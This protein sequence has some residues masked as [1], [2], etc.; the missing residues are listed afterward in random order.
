MEQQLSEFKAVIY[1][2]PGC[3]TSNTIDQLNQTKTILSKHWAPSSI[4]VVNCAHDY[5]LQKWLREESGGKRIFPQIYIGDVRIGS[6]TDLLSAQESGLLALMCNQ[7]MSSSLRL[8]LAPELQDSDRESDEEELDYDDE[9]DGEVDPDFVK[10]HVVTTWF[11]AGQWILGV[12]KGVLHFL[13]SPAEQ[14]QT[15]PEESTE[16]LPEVL[17]ID[18][19]EAIVTEPTTIIVEE[20]ILTENF[21]EEVSLPPETVQ[22][23]IVS[24]E[25]FK[26]FDLEFLR[27]NW[28]WR[29]QARVYRFK[30]DNF[31]RL[32]KLAPV[33]GSEATV[34]VCATFPY[35]K[36]SKV[37]KVD[38]KSV[39]IR[40][41]DG[42]EEQHLSSDC[43]A[44]VEKLVEVINA[45]KPTAIV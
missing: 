14:E 29:A 35:D 32:E 38:D 22:E 37:D 10:N 21:V 16:I 45:R 4:L 11:S 34:R 24:M 33:N 41:I 31:E 19:R 42:T 40:F 6:Y 2:N 28:L 20:P 13:D 25:E 1:I 36:V 3:H 17:L 27:L 5:P 30:K 44:N 18:D 43:T 15:N 12:A 26:D 7:N 39:I 9:E 8:S 23:E